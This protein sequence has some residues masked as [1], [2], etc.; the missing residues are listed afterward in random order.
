[1]FN[2]FKLQ[3]EFY[4]KYLFFYIDRFIYS[5]VKIENQSDEEQ[6]KLKK[7]NM[8]SAME[9]ILNIEEDIPSI[10][11][12]E[13]L[14]NQVN[15]NDNVPQGFRRI[16]VSAG[17]KATF[18][19][20]NSKDV[21]IRLYYLIDNYKNVWCILDP[22]EREA[23]FH[24]EFMRIHPFEDGN[25]R[26]AK[27]I[28]SRNLMHQNKAPVIIEESET[29]LYYKFINE[30]DYIGFA[31]FIETKSMAELTNMVGLFKTLNDI[32]TDIEGK[33]ITRKLT[34]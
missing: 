6:I 3:D 28:L 31:K 5:S 29:D 7:K 13:D 25:K 15:T 14:G 19:P 1:M 27:T 33:K 9:K 18:T 17:A 20:V 4:N 32:P 21:F 30:C 2:Q 24:I 10:W 16:N 11:D 26:V 12:I 23:R 22:Y 34:K 8:L